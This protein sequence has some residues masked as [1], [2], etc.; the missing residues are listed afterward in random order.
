MYLLDTQVVLELRKAKAGD[1]DLGVQKWAAEVAP[2]KLFISAITL[3]E[4]ENSV[5]R[6][7]RKDK[8]AGAALRAWL[9]DRV[10]KAFDG[11]VLA[12]DAAVARRRGNV[13][14]VNSR[15]ALLAATALVHGLTLV[16]RD[17]VAFRS[18]RAKLFN[19]WGYA[20]EAVEEDAADWRAVAKGSPLWIKNLFLRF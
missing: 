5:V 19:P 9:D 8:T 6:Q 1:A 12:L 7:E 14:L 18:S 3:L 11:R 2:P 4:L 15:D 20:P 13:P 16:T 17:V 10:M